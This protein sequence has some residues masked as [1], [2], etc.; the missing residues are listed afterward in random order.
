MDLLVNQ[1]L[2]PSIQGKAQEINQTSLFLLP[3]FWIQWPLWSITTRYLP[4]TVGKLIPL[5][6]CSHL[7]T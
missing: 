7:E 6:P 4:P 1:K 5:S 3:S 2:R